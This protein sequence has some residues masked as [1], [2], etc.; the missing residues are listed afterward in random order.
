MAYTIG[1]FGLV[2]LF[3]IVIL[4]SGM[5]VAF[6]L[7]GIGVVLTALIWGIEGLPM[8][9]NA[10]FSTFTADNFLAIPMFFLM[11]NA[12]QRSGIA[13]DLY[14]MLYKW[15]GGVKGGL[16]VGT[17][18]ICAIFGAM[19]G[20]SG[21]ATITMSL[22]ALPSMLK[23]GY[24]R[25]LC[26]GAIAT[27]GVLGIIIPPSIPMVILSPYSGISVGKLFIAGVFPGILCAII[28]IIY[29]LIRCKISPDLCPAIP[30]D[31]R[32]TLKEKIKSSTSLIAPLILV[33]LVLGSIYMGIAT[34]V[35]A[36]G[37]G[38]IGSL[39]IA[40]L[41]K[42]LNKEVFREIL[43]ETFK[44]VCMVL[45][46]LTGAAAFNTIFNYMGAYTVMQ[47]IAAQIPGGII[48]VMIFMMIL[49]F[50]FGALM[51]DFAVI[52]LTAPLYLPIIKSFGV[53]PLWFSLIFM[54]N[55]QVAY[56]TPPYGFNLF[57]LRRTVPA[58]VK[59]EEIYKSVLPFIGLQILALII[60][61]I[62]PGI[63]TWLPN[64]M[65]R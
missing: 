14:G 65:I 23:R 44:L 19:C 6:G 60:C 16:L 31:Q 41:K 17:I 37:I 32:A 24:D 29:I 22:I 5:P 64:K 11:A 36:A 27:G 42:R 57:F 47:Q 61:W 2:L 39:I 15:M 28:Y 45:W 20:G 26:M 52:T 50:I 46:I 4:F 12:L 55:L 8:I 62:F 35:E 58:D 40:Y 54:L 63:I 3:M 25:K 18:I 30:E 10:A 7:G 33:F 43:I 21:P 13:D 38:A 51:D 56:L 59:M 9:A 1:D 34:P 53:D 49:N 48:S